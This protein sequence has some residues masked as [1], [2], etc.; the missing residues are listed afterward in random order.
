V[1]KNFELLQQAEKEKELFATP[2][3]QPPAV[4]TNGSHRLK[5]VSQTR[6][7]A[8]K[9]VQRVFLLPNG[10]APRA[11]L[12]SSVDQGDGCSSVCSC[13]AE[14]LA[15]EAAGSICLV[16]ANL[17]NPSLH[18][19]FGLDNRRGLAEAV[20]QSGPIKNFAQQVPG[21]KLWVLTAGAANGNVPA[22][23]TSDGLKARLTELRGEF[24]H[25]LIDAPPVNLYADAITLGRLSDGVILVL[26]SDSTRREAAWKA[27]QSIQ[28]AD[29]RLLGAVLNKRTFPI[30]QALYE[31]L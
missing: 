7:E 12:F 18:Q 13:A 21:S 27:K 30:P 17:R 10:Q 28:A 23:L 26:E 14:A 11:V 24:D 9:L 15:S 25:V 19:Y 8:N 31:R 4:Q 1:S 5:L 16:D 2:T 20:A 22:L 3:P 6:E 29:V